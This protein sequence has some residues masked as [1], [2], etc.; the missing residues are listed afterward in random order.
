[1][2]F[3]YNTSFHRTIQT[4]PNFLTFGTLA[5]QPAFAPMDLREKYYESQSVQDRQKILK[6]AREIAWKNSVH[7]HEGYQEQYDHKAAPHNFKINQW[8]LI[9]EN[10]FLNKNAKLSEKY[11]GP[12]KILQLKGTNNAIIQIRNKKVC[13]N[14]NRLKPY[15]DSSNFK[16]FNDLQKQGSDWKESE[17]FENQNEPKTED[18][19]N[20]PRKEET[21]NSEIP[22][23]KR[24]RPRKS[25]PKIKEPEKQEEEPGW[26]QRQPT[27]T[28]VQQPEATVNQAAN[29]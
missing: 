11:D 13:V 10:Y 23:R 24:G 29:F 6:Q 21:Q 9:Q 2:M 22:K 17:K 8:V 12:F 4:S 27:E 7:Q 16:T 25:Q 15:H 5:W 19:Q 18:T 20:E 1:M 14:T 3:A 28:N 26:G